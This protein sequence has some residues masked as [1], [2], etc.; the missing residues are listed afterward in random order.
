MG[1]NSASDEIQ[2]TVPDSD[3]R[4]P[5]AQRHGL[6]GPGDRRAPPAVR[7]ATAIVDLHL[8]AGQ[9]LQAVE[10]LRLVLAKLARETHHRLVAGGEALLVDQ[11][12]V[13]GHGITA[14]PQ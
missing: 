14:Q 10:L 1:V 12:L 11:I 4:G 3:R 7:P 8:F 5:P 2:E 9:K 6:A 13:D